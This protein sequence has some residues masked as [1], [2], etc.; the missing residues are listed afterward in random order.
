L[1]LKSEAKK[2][3]SSSAFYMQLLPKMKL[4]MYNYIQQSAF[5]HPPA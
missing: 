4:E 5:P 1:A 2:A 3:F